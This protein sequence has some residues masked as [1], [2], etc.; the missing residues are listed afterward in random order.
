MNYDQTINKDFLLK[1]DEYFISTRL[2]YSDEYS[3]YDKSNLDLD[4]TNKKEKNHLQRVASD[5]VM[6]RK[7]QIAKKYLTDLSHNEEEKYD[8][9]TFTQTS[10]MSLPNRSHSA[11]DMPTKDNEK[12]QRRSELLY[13][14]NPLVHQRLLPHSKMNN[15]KDHLFRTDEYIN[16]NLFLRID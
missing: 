4:I 1:S 15:E 7:N 11:M 13:F 14:N 8:N 9:R 5:P 16:V 12:L 2:S 10:T 6:F 3:T